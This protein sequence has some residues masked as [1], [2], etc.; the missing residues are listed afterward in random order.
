MQQNRFL[1]EFPRQDALEQ[2][3]KDCGRKSRRSAA[4]LGLILCVAL[5]LS[6]MAYRAF[7]KSWEQDE[8]ARPLEELAAEKTL[9]EKLQEQADASM[10]TIQIYSGP[11]F[12]NGAAEG[13]LYIANAESNR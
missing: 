6:L 13:P 7:A 9:Q 4:A 5:G 1:E 12:E 8:N 10:F 3:R 2:I 11:E